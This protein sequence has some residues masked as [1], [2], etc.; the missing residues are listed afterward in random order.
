MLY[1]TLCSCAVLAFGEVGGGQVV[2]RVLTCNKCN[3]RTAPSHAVSRPLR[4]DASCSA[5]DMRGKP[6][7]PPP[8][9]A[10]LVLP[11]CVRAASGG[12][13]TL[14]VHAKPGARLA[15][16]VSVADVAEVSIDAPPR[17]GEANDALCGFLA[18]TLGVKRRAVTLQTGGKSRDK[19]FH[20]ELE[21]SELAARLR[22]ALASA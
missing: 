15:A 4:A 18:D 20:V 17:E 21:P 10:A 22:G 7:P 1:R 16:L 11:P 13:S 19:V 14:A 6:P 8:P 12:G 3:K 5:R 9:D 2:L